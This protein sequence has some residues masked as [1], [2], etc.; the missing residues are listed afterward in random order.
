MIVVNILEEVFIDFFIG[1]MFIVV[2]DFKVLKV[3]K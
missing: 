2:V 3:M 1:E